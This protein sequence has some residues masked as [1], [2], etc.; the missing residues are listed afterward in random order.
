[1]CQKAAQ[2]LQSNTKEQ[3]FKDPEDVYYNI[4]PLSGFDVDTEEPI[5]ARPFKPKF[6]MTMGMF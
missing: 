3:D 5:K 1:V 6:H 2:P 4:T